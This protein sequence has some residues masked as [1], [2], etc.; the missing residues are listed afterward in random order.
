MTLLVCLLLL[1]T[2]VSIALVLLGW[3]GSLV[4]ASQWP[5]SDIASTDIFDIY[6]EAK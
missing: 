3:K 1:V 6:K 4:T 2:T 5:G